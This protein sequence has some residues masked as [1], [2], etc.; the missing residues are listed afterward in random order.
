M[1][2][3]VFFK[4]CASSGDMLG[5]VR[6]KKSPEGFPRASSTSETL[7]QSMNCF[8]GRLVSFKFACLLASTADEYIIFIL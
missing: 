6:M 4:T 5:S 2:G 3:A 8:A 7:T 1:R